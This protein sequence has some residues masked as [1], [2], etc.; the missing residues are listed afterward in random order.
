[1]SYADLE[2]GGK[3]LTGLCLQEKE[4]RGFV[5]VEM[6]LLKVSGLTRYLEKR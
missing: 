1:M 6:C 3:G 2:W 4:G 5:R